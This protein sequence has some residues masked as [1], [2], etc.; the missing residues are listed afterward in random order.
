MEIETIKYSDGD[1][2]VYHVEMK[3]EFDSCDWCEFQNSKLYRDLN[4]FVKRRKKV[5]KNNSTITVQV[6]NMDDELITSID[7][8]GEDSVGITQD[9]YKVFVNG[10]LLGIENSSNNE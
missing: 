1:G 5:I 2:S 6:A 3:I 4:D 10:K 8:D 9:G 7:T